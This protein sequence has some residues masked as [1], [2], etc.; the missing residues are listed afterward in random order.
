MENTTNQDTPNSEIDIQDI[1]R[2][3]Y[4]QKYDDAFKLIVQLLDKAEEKGGIQIHKNT[5]LDSEDYFLKQYTRLAGALT[6]F[7]GHPKVQLPPKSFHLLSVHKKHILGIFQLSGFRGTDHLLA[8]IGEQGNKKGAKS[9]FS[10]Q[11]EHQLIKFLLFYSIY[12]EADI[13]FA[14]LLQAFPEL[15]LSAYLNIACEECVL[16]STA[17]AKRDR[18]LEL[19]PLLENIPLDDNALTR[20]SNLWMYCSYAH[21]QNKHDIKKHLNV[22]MQK[23]LAGKGVKIPTLPPKRIKTTRPVLLI[24][25]ERFTS[26]H[27]MYRCYAPAIQQL[28]DK[29]QLVVMSEPSKMD[30]ISKQLFDEVIEVKFKPANIKQWVGKVVKIKPDIIYYP[31]LGMGVWTLLLANLRLAPIQMMTLGHPATSHSPVIDYVLAREI[32][33]SHEVHCFSET[34]ILMD[35]ASVMHIPPQK[36][37][38]IPPQIR[39]HPSPVRLAITST[40]LKLNA[41]FMD[42]CRQIVQQSQKPLEFHFFPSELG[43]LYHR[44]KQRIHDWLPEAKVYP[45]ADYNAYMANLNQCDIHLSPFPFGGTNSNID[46]MKQGLPIV[47]L[48]GHEPHARTDSIFFELSNLPNWLLTH[49]EEE[50][51]AAALRLIHNDEERVAIGES[52]LTQDFEN[53]FRDHDFCNHEKVF[54]KTVEWLYQHHEK[55]QKEG[56]KVWTSEAQEE[57]RQHNFIGKER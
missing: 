6:S 44:V 10:I 24:P 50:Y 55:I 21:Y 49:T 5:D 25:S 31:S 8:L 52:L 9:D 3:T 42:T 53:I 37:A 27:A 22:V 12:S 11:S 18:L 16:T 32:V 54:S 20:L 4:Q 43:M 35:T 14:P 2:L 1:E 51:M 36:A 28:R 15:T 40:A 56:R 46:S 47:A 41:S 29:F 39:S 57:L 19:G 33:Y 23:W 17:R 38:T 7:F 48:E 45:Y 34:V 13:D 30:D 26:S